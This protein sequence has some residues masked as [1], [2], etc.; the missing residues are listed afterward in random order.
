MA[1][2]TY[3]CYRK[4]AIKDRTQTYNPK[5]DTFV[6][7]DAVSGQFMDVKQD[8]SPFKGVAKEIDHR[9]KR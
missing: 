7:R 8:G 1:I 3:K 2:N 4:G 9:R 5:N 6:K